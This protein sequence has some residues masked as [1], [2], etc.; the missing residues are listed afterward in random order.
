MKRRI[1]H[2]IVYNDKI[3]ISTLLLFAL[4]LFSVKNV[5]VKKNNV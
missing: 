5:I 4:I 2:D 3:L 1:I